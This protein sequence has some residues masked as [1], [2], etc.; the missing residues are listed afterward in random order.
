MMFDAAAS[1]AAFAR[2]FLIFAIRHAY[3]LSCRH[4][5]CHRRLFYC[6]PPTSFRLIYFAIHCQLRHRRRCGEA[7]LS[8]ADQPRRLCTPMLTLRQMLPRRKRA[9]K[10]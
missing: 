5:A 4:D 10:Q 9:A 2:C 7:R 6:R 8:H 3:C 1:A